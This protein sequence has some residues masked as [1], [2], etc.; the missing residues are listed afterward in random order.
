MNLKDFNI[1]ELPPNTIRVYSSNT[2]YRDFNSVFE[3]IS[4]KGSRII[5]KRTGGPSFLMNFDLDHLNSNL[6]V[7]YMNNGKF[8]DGKSKLW[9]KDNKLIYAQYYYDNK[10]LISIK[11]D[12]QYS[13]FLKIQV[14]K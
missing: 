2:K 3:Y 10:Q 13:K 1:E 7:H 12:Q 9:F 4:E 8:S 6:Y 11:T 14:F 5:Q